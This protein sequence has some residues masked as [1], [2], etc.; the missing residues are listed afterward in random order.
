VLRQSSQLLLGLSQL[1]LQLADLFVL[2]SNYL[3]VMDD[4]LVDL[5][6]YQFYDLLIPVL[7]ITSAINARPEEVRE[8]SERS[9]DA[10]T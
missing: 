8:G 3:F 6:P 7:P 5:Y 9:F 1:S 4:V 10:N 2:G